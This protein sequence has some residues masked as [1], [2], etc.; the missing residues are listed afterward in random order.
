M[1]KEVLKGASFVIAGMVG[2]IVFGWGLG[3]IAS[4]FIIAP[5][6][7]K[8][9]PVW[10]CVEGK[11]YEKIDDVYVTVNPARSCLPVIKD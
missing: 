7:N 10:Y 11:I 2:A 9:Q 6:G 5:G 8:V 3:E 4:T 1:V